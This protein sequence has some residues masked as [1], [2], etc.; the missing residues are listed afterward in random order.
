M[1]IK[2]IYRS[3]LFLAAPAAAAAMLA[4][5]IASPPQAIAGPNV[6]GCVDVYGV[7]ACGSAKVPN[8]NGVSKVIPNVSVPNINMPNIKVPKV[9]VPNVKVP[10]VGRR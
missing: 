10:K 4:A 2:R 6:E 1:R 9:K 8:I 3:A 5:S 7:S